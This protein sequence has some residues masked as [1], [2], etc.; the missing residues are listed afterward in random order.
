M[1]KRT[2]KR[3]IEA[4]NSVDYGWRN[5]VIEMLAGLRIF[6]FSLS[7][8]T[9]IEMRSSTKKT[10]ILLTYEAFLNPNTLTTYFLS[11]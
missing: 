1:S 4:L 8:K 9:R 2:G 11:E 5:E 10:K 7:N 3:K 6:R